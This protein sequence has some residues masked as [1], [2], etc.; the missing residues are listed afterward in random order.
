VKFG[1]IRCIEEMNISTFEHN[2]FIQLLDKHKV[3]YLLVSDNAKNLANDADVELWLKPT[4]RNK[5][6]L[7]KAI[8]GYGYQGQLLKT[9]MFPQYALAND[10]K[11]PLKNEIS[12]S[13]KLSNSYKFDEIKHMA[14]IQRG[15][16]GQ[17]VRVVDYQ[18]L[19][20]VVPTK[21][22]KK[23]AVK[24]PSYDLVHSKGKVR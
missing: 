11:L 2:K 16:N 14:T 24:S 7:I 23:S 8:N 20:K 9:K 22:D 13:S 4:E 19:A 17:P 3:E 1:C 15:R 10:I 12:I 6:K 5:L 21:I 18:S